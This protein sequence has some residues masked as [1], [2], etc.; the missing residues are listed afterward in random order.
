MKK[1]RGALG[2]CLFATALLFAACGS[3]PEPVTE[4]VTVEVPVV[5]TQVI[6]ETQPVEV[7][8]VVTATPEPTPA[9]VSRI[10]AP[11]GTLV[12]PLT[13]APASLDPQMAVDETAGLVVEQLYESLF[14]LRGDGTL[15]PAAATG[16][17]VSPDGQTYTVT[18]RSGLTW[19]DGAP[20]TARHYVDGL[21]RLLEPATGNSYYYLLTEILAITGARD[22]ASGDV[23][24]CATIGFQATDESTISITLE[25]PAGFLPGLLAF[26]T[27]L[28]Y[29][30]DLG[31]PG[32]ITNGP[33]ILE[34]WTPDEGLTLVKNPGYWNADA[35]AIE[36]IEF[37]FVADAADQLSRYEAGDFHVAQFPAEQTARI[38]ADP[39]F[40]EELQVLVQPGT[41]YLG[42]NTQITPTLD[43]N[44][45]R[46]VVSAIDRD[47][48][49]ADVLEQP[50]R[51][52]AQVVVPPGIVG[53]QGDDPTV[54]YAYDP[55]KAREFLALAG[56]NADNPPP[57]VELWFNREGNNELLFKAVAAMLEEVGI[58]VRLVSSSWDVHRDTLD[59]CNAPNRS[60]A[61]SPAECSYNLYR[62]GWVMDYADPS[63]I[64]DIVFSPQSAFQ[65]TGWA[66]PAYEE[67]MQ[68][69][70]AETDQAART[71]LYHQAER[72]LLNE[73]VVVA[74]LQF[75]DRT[76]LVKSGVAFDYPA[77][78]AP[79]LQYWRLP[80]P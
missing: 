60:A 27:F 62:M 55:Q 40:A 23:A 41:S 50:W 61:G 13:V 52:P 30:A 24:D 67:L 68:Q 25:R 33:Y 4:P 38:Q 57:P 44:V 48:L 47:A 75:Y 42:L 45:R 37:P 71:E 20:L 11:A 49:I 19:S 64:L 63:S 65:Y 16:Y 80:S 69:A 32:R 34:D 43:V 59:A 5:Q 17:T 15:E 51:V 35:V 54:G 18:L 7:T 58:P 10:N 12:Y 29:R 26:R 73:E 53:F 9:Y 6:V 21:C 28:P 66:S 39:T 2:I 70:R 76:L 78:G 31:E 36:R 79:Q 3:D 14:H 56:F 72:L 8:V 22:F 77:F 74:P 1:M 46:A